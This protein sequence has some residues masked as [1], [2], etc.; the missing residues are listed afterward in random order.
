MSPM[1]EDK[2]FPTPIEIADFQ[3]LMQAAKTWFQSGNLAGFQALFIQQR[4]DAVDSAHREVT[5]GFNRV[6]FPAIMAMESFLAEHVLSLELVS[7][8]SDDRGAGAQLYKDKR[9]GARV[10]V[11]RDEVHQFGQH[12][13]WVL[14]WARERERKRQE[15][16]L[17]LNEKTFGAGIVKI[18]GEEHEEKP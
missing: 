9:T 12:I 8:I 17:A 16:K 6:V 14:S 13:A 3:H 7:D 11:N 15:G 2:R 18:A 10:L 1:P 4:W 5:A